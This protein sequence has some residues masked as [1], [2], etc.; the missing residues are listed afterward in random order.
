MKYAL[1]LILAAVLVTVTSGVYAQEKGGGQ[2]SQYGQQVSEQKKHQGQQISEQKKHQGQQMREQKMHQ[3]QQMNQEKKQQGQQA[4]QQKK[5]GE[6]LQKKTGKPG[7]DAGTGLE[8][9]I[10]D[11]QKSDQD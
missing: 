5:S 1:T 9:T 4:M 3:G 7:S 2:K 6:A 8:E 11:N 10:G